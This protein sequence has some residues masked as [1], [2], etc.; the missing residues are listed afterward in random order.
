M[1]CDH[2][3]CARCSAFSFLEIMVVVVIIMVEEVRTV[4][5]VA[6]GGKPG[7]AINIPLLQ[8]IAIAK[9]PKKRRTS[10]RH[11][12]HRPRVVVSLTSCV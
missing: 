8:G 6:H 7:V 5:K 9:T 4:D 11:S 2:K 3:R 10:L 1:C 12:W